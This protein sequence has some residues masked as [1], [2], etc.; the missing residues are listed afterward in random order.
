MTRLTAAVTGNLKQQMEETGKQIKGA[1]RAAVEVAT[2]ELQLK[3]RVA[4]NRAFPGKGRGGAKVGN[5]IRSKVYERT[6]DP[7]GGFTGLVWSKFGR[8]GAVG[9]IDY[10]LPHVQGATITPRRGAKYL[11]ISVEKGVGAKRRRRLAV[12]L[13]PKLRFVAG[14]RGRIYLVRQVTKKRTKL[15]AVLVPRVRILKRIDIDK[16]IDAAESNMTNRLLTEL[17]KIA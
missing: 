4:V 12:A 11:Y 17:D 14:S 16:E 2:R 3:I 5:A 13:D 9:F 10:L 7:D 6:K 1:S 15:I 8:R